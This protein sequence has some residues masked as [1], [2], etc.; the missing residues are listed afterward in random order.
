MPSF[1]VHEVMKE[2]I[3]RC[4]KVREQLERARERLKRICPES[5]PSDECTLKAKEL[6]REALANVEKLAKRLSLLEAKCIPGK[7]IE[8]V[9]LRISKTKEYNPT[10][11]WDWMDHIYKSAG[12]QKKTVF[13]NHTKYCGP[14]HEKDKNIRDHKNGLN[15]TPPEIV[16]Q[17]VPGDRFYFNNQ[18]DADDFG[19][20]SAI[21]LGWIDH[22]A[23]HARIASGSA[24]N[25]GRIHEVFLR[26]KGP[27][28]NRLNEGPI[29]LISHAVFPKKQQE[30]LAKYMD[31]ETQKMTPELNKIDEL[32]SKV[33]DQLQLASL[34]NRMGT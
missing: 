22:E 11:C 15:H 31:D 16:D 27:G 17:I 18:N 21:F 23:R 14:K 19:N 28:P 32:T 6:Y 20:H 4:D 24:G 3:E 7:R 34:E 25:P 13:D 8:Q 29:T 2:N 26:E 1:D 5:M 12:V 9:A 33:E 30:K 10:C